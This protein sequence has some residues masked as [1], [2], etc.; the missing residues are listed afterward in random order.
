MV[1][2]DLLQEAKRRFCAELNF[3]DLNCEV[4]V[5]RPLS[6]RDAIGDPGRNDFPI[7][8]GKE[9]L[10]QAVYKDVAGQAFTSSKGSF[11]GTL[12]DVLDMP[13]AGSFERAVL[14]STINAVLR[15]RGLIDKTVH[16]KDDGPKRCADCMAYWIKEQHVDDVG[17]IGMQPALL[18]ALVR[19]QGAGR[20]MVSD[21]ADAGSTRCGIKVLDGM[22]PSEMFERCQLILITGS[23]IANGTIDGL[24]EKASYHK[25]R[26]V[27]FGTTIAGVA[28]LLGMER[29]CPCST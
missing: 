11:K 26:V 15:Y 3:E 12:R 29:W 10:M 2:K 18:E 13:L 1:K 6:P 7:L 24:L 4:V 20:V 23:T 9:V 28:Y 14:V 19:V 5:S 8:R 16:C 22:N 17:L 27:F 21:L 25:R